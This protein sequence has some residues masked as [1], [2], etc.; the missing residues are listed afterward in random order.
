MKA[1][2]ST[3]SATL[4]GRALTINGIR[5]IATKYSPRL[6]KMK[7]GSEASYIVATSSLG[8]EVELHPR[9]VKDLFTKGEAAGIK[10]LVDTVA[11]TTPV[12]ATPVATTESVPVSEPMAPAKVA[13]VKKT[14][15]KQRAIE[16][17]NEAVTAGETRQYVIKR[18]MS[19]LDMTLNGC[20]TYYQSIKT[21]AWV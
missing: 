9:T 6:G 12:V 8:N 13:A 19:E 18:W 21:G 17:F 4:I 16:I 14:F 2:Y 20:N 10:M 15:K 7:D 1:N 5:H 11:D 3:L